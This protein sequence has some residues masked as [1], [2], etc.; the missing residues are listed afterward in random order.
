MNQPVWDW[1]NSRVYAGLF[2]N[3][4]SVYYTAVA[5]SEMTGI[6]YPLPPFRIGPGLLNPIKM[7]YLFL[8]YGEEP[9]ASAKSPILPQWKYRSL[10]NKNSLS[11]GR[12]P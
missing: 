10:F 1:D 5:L 3:R 9:L 4:L 11:G 7:L 6:P 12:R 2:G 8:K